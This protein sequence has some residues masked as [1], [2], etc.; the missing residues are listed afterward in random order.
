MKFLVISDTH[1]KI[2]RAAEIYRKLT[3]I[4]FLVH[5]GDYKRDGQE[6]ARSFGV[7]CFCKP[8]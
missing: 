1:G 2:G 8:G 3:D 4:D 6:L 5:L 7:D